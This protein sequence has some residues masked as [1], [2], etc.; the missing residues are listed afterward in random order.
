MDSPRLEERRV[1]MLYEGVSVKKGGKEVCGEGCRE[2]V[3][4]RVNGESAGM[5]KG[6]GC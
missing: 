2:M 4:L 5:F 6:R 1:I 3:L